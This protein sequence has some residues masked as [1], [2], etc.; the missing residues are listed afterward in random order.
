MQLPVKATWAAL[1]GAPGRAP[2][3][4]GR[5]SSAALGRTLGLPCRAQA[6]PFQRGGS[7]NDPRPELASHAALSAEAPTA[8]AAAAVQGLRSQH[9][10]QEQQAAATLREPPSVEQQL[11]GLEALCQELR[12]VEAY[13][14]KVGPPASCA[15]GL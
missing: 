3:P 15:P 13:A 7:G 5:A 1:R 9:Q 10:Q 14:D 12:G 11:R 2:Q 8:P 4:R 6:R